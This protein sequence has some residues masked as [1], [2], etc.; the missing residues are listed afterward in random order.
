M[1]DAGS[2]G[3]VCALAGVRVVGD[4]PPGGH[5]PFESLRVIGIANRPYDGVWGVGSR[6]YDGVWWSGSIVRVRC[7]G[8]PLAPPLWIPAFA[9]MTSVGRRNDERGAQE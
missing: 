2:Q 8:C 6:P 4:A 3:A 7:R 1:R 9:G 5:S